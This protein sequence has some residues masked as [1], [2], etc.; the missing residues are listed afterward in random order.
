MTNEAKTNM[1]MGVLGYINENN[2]K[3][4]YPTAYNLL[5]NNDFD[6]QKIIK[7]HNDLEFD[8]RTKT[9][10]ISLAG[11]YATIKIKMSELDDIVELVEKHDVEIGIG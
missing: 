5:E 8:E 7:L 9:S 4:D 11:S 10:F 2:Y 3:N 1:L 6:M